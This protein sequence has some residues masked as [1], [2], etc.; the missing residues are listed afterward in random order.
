MEQTSDGYKIQF[1]EVEDP[2]EV[3]EQFTKFSGEPRD[4]RKICVYNLILD[5]F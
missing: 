2:S 5:E 3:E 1:E 4:V